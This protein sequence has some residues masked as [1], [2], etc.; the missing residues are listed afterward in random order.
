MLYSEH[1]RAFRAWHVSNL[2][3][4][5]LYWEEPPL[6]GRTV[7]PR[8]RRFGDHLKLRVERDGVSVAAE[9]NW[10]TWDLPF[11]AEV[12]VRRTDLG[13][14]CEQDPEG[15]AGGIEQ[16]WERHLYDP[17][18]AWAEHTLGAAAVLYFCRSGRTRWAALCND[19]A[20]VPESAAYAIYAED[21]K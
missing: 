3:R 8:L 14:A 2:A 11:V 4:A 15:T 20:S 10:E 7:E 16:L 13:F 19:P 9:F 5:S 21:T 12:E 1:A 6:L 17:L 18:L